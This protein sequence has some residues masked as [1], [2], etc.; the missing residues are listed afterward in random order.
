MKTLIIL[1]SSLIAT[2]C[3][4]MTPAQKN[5]VKTVSVVLIVGAIAAHNG[6]M[7]AGAP[8]PGTVGQAGLPCRPQPD[9]SCR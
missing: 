7:S 6:A 4:S 8:A 9:G 2:G 1:F 3:A 5:V